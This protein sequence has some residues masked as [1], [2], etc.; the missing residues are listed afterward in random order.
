MNS[1]R[2]AGRDALV[3]LHEDHQ[4]IAG[5]FERVESDVTAF[6]EIQAELRAHTHIEEEIFYPALREALPVSEREAIDEAID[7][8]ADVKQMLSEMSALAADRAELKEGLDALRDS[9]LEHVEIEEDDL[10]ARAR[11]ILTPEALAEMG[12]RM[13]ARKE[14]LLPSLA[15][16]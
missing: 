7:D 11:A 16:A 14:E 15:H 3:L 8:H 13:A 5:L 9:V 12:E 10:F 2:E 6:E 4:R 1:N